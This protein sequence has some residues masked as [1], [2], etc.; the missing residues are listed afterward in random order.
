MS[1]KKISTGNRQCSGLEGFT[2]RMNLKIMKFVVF[3]NFYSSGLIS[4]P[5]KCFQ[6]LKEN[7]TSRLILRFRVMSLCCT[8]PEK[9]PAM[10]SF[11]GPRASSGWD[12]WSFLPTP[13]PINLKIFSLIV[14]NQKMA[15]LENWIQNYKMYFSRVN[16]SKYNNFDNLYPERGK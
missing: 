16:T 7:G 6:Y 13:N 4:F 1:T 5:L 11:T 10:A 12:C 15:K 8:V 2:M 9:A 14:A 3:S